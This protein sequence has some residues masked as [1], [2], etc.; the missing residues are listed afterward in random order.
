MDIQVIAGAIQEIESELIVVNLFEGVTKPGG[1]T[2]AVDG[3]LDGAIQ[4]LVDAGD[5]KGESGETVVLYTRGAIP[6]RRVLL[7]GLGNKESFD[8]DRLRRVS[9]A[10]AR[11]VQALRIKSFHSIVHG[12]G[13]GGLDLG[14]AAQALVEG[15]IL[16]TYRFPGQKTDLSALEPPIEALTLVEFDE[17]RVP[18]IRRAV[19][20]GRIVAEAASLARDLVNRPAN[21]LT[22]TM[23]ADVAQDVADEGELSC[24]VLG[25]AAM[26][27]L[28]MGAL[29]AV[30]QGSE[31]PAK[32]VILEHNAGEKGLDTLVVIGKG[33]TFDSGGISLKSADGMYR[34]KFDMGGAGV[35]LGVMQAV[36][37]LNLPLHVVGLMPA[38]ENLPGGRAYKPGDV[39]ESMSGLSIEVISTDAEGRL[40][41]ADALHYA[42]RYQPKAVVDLATLTG[43]C[44]VA[45]GHTASG[46]FAN[47]DDLTTAL[48]QASE[49]SGEKV[50]PLPLFEE[51]DQHIESDVA[52]VKNSGGRPA[53][54]VTAAMFL[55]KFIG[56]YAWAHLDIAGT[57][58]S[59][60]DDGYLTKGATGHGV[61]LLVQ[62]LCDCCDTAEG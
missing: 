15:A 52:D 48:R 58:W 59:D 33:I 29:L 47:D 36:A 23:L 40:L 42:K 35:T 56:E 54:A 24:Q 28:G 10:V 41:L 62:W 53:A 32:F 38:T 9:A 13:A 43:A 60:K 6:A 57:T 5:F 34:M 27:E 22:P 26:R 8:L 19:R 4:E 51:Y 20:V 16:G 49:R 39:L 44:V 37:A 31:E 25:E 17:A 11:R 30:A 45:L 2:G 3:A 46:L 55:K 18:E 61:R 14:K 50:W 12:A 7:V 1:A 21:H